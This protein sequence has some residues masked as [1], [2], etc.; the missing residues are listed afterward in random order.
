MKLGFACK[1]FDSE[2]KQP[3]PFKTTTRTRFLAMERNAAATL[4]LALAQNNLQNLSLTLEQLA[5]QPDALRMMRIG[6]DLL[7]LYTVPLATELYG[8]ILPELQPL[9]SRCGELARAHNIRLSFHPGQYTVLASDN[10]DVVDRA[11]EDVEYHTLCAVLMG[12]GRQFQDFKINIHMNGK[13]GIEGFRAAFM[14]LSPEAR[15]MLTVENDEISCSLDDVLQARAL[16][17]VVL[18]IHHHWVKE[19]QFI[20]ASD[21]RVALILESWRGVR[22]V[23]H[24]S[25][26]QE[27]LIPESGFPDQEQLA[28]SKPKLRAHSDYYFNQ[29]LNDWALSFD[30]FDI[31]CEVKMKNLARDRLYDYAQTR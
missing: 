30:R 14:R 23:L 9:F 11:L 27:G 28:A 5:Q 19:N 12:Y 8:D 26:A 7:P 6:S 15:N 29:T 17:P 16:C 2:A 24:Y 13:R 22:P 4:L 31:M 25:I 21:E 1:Y 10:D 3:F 20:Q 18:D